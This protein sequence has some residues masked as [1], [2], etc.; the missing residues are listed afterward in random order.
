[1][2]RR[3]TV[4][5]LAVV[6]GTLVLTVAG[7]VLLVRGAAIETAA[8]ELTTEA[9]AIGALMSSNPAFSD[10]AVLPVL[11]RVGAFDRLTLVGLGT[12]ARVRPVPA[13][14]VPAVLRPRALQSGATVAGHVGN[15][16]FVAQPLALTAR[17]RVTLAGGLPAADT[18]VL[19]VTRHVTNPVNGVF[20]FVLVAGAVLAAAVL[21]ATVLARRISAPLVRA[22]GATRQIAGGN[23]AA[24]VAVSAHDY[25]E[26]AELAQAINTLG[27]N[28]TRSQGLEREFLLSVS[29]ELRTPLTSIR[30]YADAIAEGATDDVPGAVAI[31]ATEARRLERLVQDLLDLARVQARQF[32]L[33][34]QRVDCADVAASV[35]E[36]FR[37]EAGAAGVALVAAVAP[38]AGLWV[39][40]DP[41]RL[42]QIIANLVENAL[43]F[44]AGRVEV[45]AARAG[46]WTGV[47][48]TDDGPGMGAEDLPHVFE[49]HYTSDRMPARKAG[50]GLGLAIV[51]ELAAAMGATVTAESPAAAGRG[52]RMAVWL[53]SDPAPGGHHGPTGGVTAPGDPGIPTSALPLRPPA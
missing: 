36:G 8:N 25:P 19:V 43:K 31:I 10:R 12:D 46:A 50:A 48:V 17:Q 4:A 39:D 34:T 44:A 23:L 3:I 15:V 28:L 35:V 11:R 42:G 6:L 38:G 52:A 16:V 1:M 9:E 41:D 21:V 37:P 32:S 26:L 33:H 18:P 40:A 20:Y 27:E 13:P 29:H 7:S 49:R 47:W 5:I 53:A 51:A 24:T 2:R 30:G 45:G 22:L 14:L